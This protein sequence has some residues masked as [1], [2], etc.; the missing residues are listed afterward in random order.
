LKVE[1]QGKSIRNT[2]SV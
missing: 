2:V 1:K